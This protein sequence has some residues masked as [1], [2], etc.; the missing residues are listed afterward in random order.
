MAGRIW[1][2][3]EGALKSQTKPWME[4]RGLRSEVYRYRWVK[5]ENALKGME[6]HV[7]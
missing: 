6:K 5:T 4:V 2:N 1:L 3:C 7:V